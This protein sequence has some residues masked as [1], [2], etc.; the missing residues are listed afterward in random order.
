L[1][2]YPQNSFV[3]ATAVQNLER[4]IVLSFITNS[5][6]MSQSDNISL[7]ELQP[8]VLGEQQ[9]GHTNQDASHLGQASL[10]QSESNKTRVCVL[11]GVA[12][13]QLP[14]WGMQPNLPMIT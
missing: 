13:L 7:Y 8:A 14:I 1:L 9:D 10:R 2:I 12:M 4:I 6:K 11:L 5:S 3:I